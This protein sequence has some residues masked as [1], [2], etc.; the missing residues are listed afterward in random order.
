M[1]ERTANFIFRR[2]SI[3]MFV[4]IIYGF[5]IALSEKV[6]NNLDFID[7]NLT[8]FILVI[9]TS[10]IIAFILTFILHL[11]FKKFIDELVFRRWYHYTHL[12]FLYISGLIVALSATERV[13]I[14]EKIIATNF[15]NNFHFANIIFFIIL[16]N[17][18]IYNSI[19]INDDFKIFNALENSY[20]N[21]STK[22]EDS[23][24]IIKILISAI[25]ITIMILHIIWPDLT[26]DSITIT[27]FILAMI[28]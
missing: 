14:E 15:S 26:I 13:L 18:Y 11:F 20:N 3:P 7:N 23:S 12:L 4:F 17:Y 5:T 27:L 28:P 6:F 1:S 19:F 22:K 24:F 9:I 16:S 25:A 8:S 10:S 2:L 21:N